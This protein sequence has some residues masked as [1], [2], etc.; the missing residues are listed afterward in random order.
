MIFSKRYSPSIYVYKGVTFP[1]D[2]NNNFYKCII[3]S[4]NIF[5]GRI[6][7]ILTH[8]LHTLRVVKP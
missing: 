3:I 8:Q 5:L 1:N 2:A 6:A 7:K 4:V